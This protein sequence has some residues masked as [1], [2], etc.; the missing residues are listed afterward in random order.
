[1]RYNIDNKGKRE[2][3]ENNIL[4]VGGKQTDKLLIILYNN[5]KFKN[6]IV[7]SNLLLVNCI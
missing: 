2:L 6:H 4:F 3:I 1:M 5:L 7:M